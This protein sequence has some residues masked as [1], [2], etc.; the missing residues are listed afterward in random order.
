LGQ[1]KFEYLFSQYFIS[2]LKKNCGFFIYK[3]YICKRLY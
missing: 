3:N 1:N 2:N